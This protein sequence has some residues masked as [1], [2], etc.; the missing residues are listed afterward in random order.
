MARAFSPDVH[1]RLETFRAKA[2]KLHEDWLSILQSGAPLPGGVAVEALGLVARLSAL[3][4][5]A[6]QILQADRDERR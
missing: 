1:D 4:A 3:S 5:R 6:D 2:R